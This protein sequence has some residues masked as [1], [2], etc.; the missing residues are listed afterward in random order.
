MEREFAMPKNRFEEVMK[1]LELSH[2]GKQTYPIAPGYL[3]LD[4]KMPPFYEE[5]RKLLI[6]SSK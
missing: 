6:E 1:G 5:L 2:E 3:E 4:Y